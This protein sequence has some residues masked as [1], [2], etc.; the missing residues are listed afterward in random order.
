MVIDIDEHLQFSV[1]YLFAGSSEQGL[2]C[3][4]H[5]VVDQRQGHLVGSEQ[6]LEPWREPGFIVDF[7]RKLET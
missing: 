2:G 7:Q 6:L 1:G 5:G 4:I 3:G